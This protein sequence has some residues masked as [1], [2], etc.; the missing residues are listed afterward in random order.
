MVTSE[1]VKRI[2]T[3]ISMVTAFESAVIAALS[4]N[5]RISTLRTLKSW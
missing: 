3:M 2:V 1:K 4:G 5:V